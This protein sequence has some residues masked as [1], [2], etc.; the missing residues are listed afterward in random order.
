MKSPT[1]RT[2]SLPEVCKPERSGQFR[3]GQ[4]GT[5][6]DAARLFGHFV[7]PAEK[8]FP[9]HLFLVRAVQI[10]SLSDR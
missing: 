2:E 6:L 7:L 8:V 4:T 9:S 1:S 10:V 5:G 3:S